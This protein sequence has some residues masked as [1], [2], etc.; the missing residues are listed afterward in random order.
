VLRALDCP[1]AHLAFD[2]AGVGALAALGQRLGEDLGERRL[3][4]V[5]EDPGGKIP[6]GCGLSDG[7]PVDR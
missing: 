2:D 5:R 4:G 6:A 3:M 1:V 7:R